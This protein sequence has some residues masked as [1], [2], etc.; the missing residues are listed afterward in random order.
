MLTRNPEEPRDDD[1]PVQLRHARGRF[2]N[3]E[4]I[5]ITLAPDCRALG[6]TVD[7]FNSLSLEPPLVRWSLRRRTSS[8]GVFRALPRFAVNL[9]TK[10]QNQLLR[11]LASRGEHRFDPPCW[12]HNGASGLP[13]RAGAAASFVCEAAAR[14]EA[15]DH[16]LFIGRALWLSENHEAPMMSYGGRLR[17]L[18]LLWQTRPA[19]NPAVTPRFYPAAPGA[20]VARG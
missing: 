1:H 6:L 3:G 15:C 5:A 14:H 11:Q 2:A 4:T 18:G 9:L 8:L 19:G 12:Q 20:N 17:G 10:G 7:S 16:D 13:L